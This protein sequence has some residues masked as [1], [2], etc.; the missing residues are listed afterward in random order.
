MEPMRVNK[1]AILMIKI[2]LFLGGSKL[3]ED[4]LFRAT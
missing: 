2:L 3:S 1:E 4:T